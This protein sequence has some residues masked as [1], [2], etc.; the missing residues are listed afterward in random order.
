MILDMIWS[1]ML[2][3]HVWILEL[4]E[5]IDLAIVY[6]YSFQLRALA[7]DFA[8]QSSALWSVVNLDLVYD[9]LIA[10]FIIWIAAIFM[11]VIMGWLPRKD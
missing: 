5:G 4:I 11:R 8:S 9:G 1:M 6:S 2:S 7:R 10:L 3:F